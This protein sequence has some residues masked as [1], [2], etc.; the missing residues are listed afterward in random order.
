MPAIRVHHTDT[1]TESAWDGP[2]EVAAAPE[3]EA[4]L[5]Y[6]HAWVDP[7]ADPNTKTAYKFPHHAAGTDT[8][9]NIRG[10]NNALARLP[11]ADIPEGDRA[12]VEAHLRAHRED[13]GLEDAAEDQLWNAEDELEDMLA[14]KHIRSRSATAGRTKRRHEPIRVF[15]GSARPHEAFWSWKNAI[16]GGTED[17]G[18][19]EMELYGYISEFSWFDDDI[20]PK[21]FKKDLLTYGQGGPIT[22]KLNSPG[23]DVIAA[24]LISTM[25]RDYPG[26]VTV[27]IDGMA[28]SAATVV[29]L[30]G[31][32]VKIQDTAYFMIHDPLVAFF[33][34]VLNIEELNRLADSLQAVKEGIVNAYEAKTGLS[35]PRLSKM[36]TDETWMDAQKALDLGFV[37]EI[38]SQGSKIP[39]SLPQ[40][41]AVVNALRNYTHV[42]PAILEA[43]KS[44]HVPEATAASAPL[45]TEDEKREAQSLSERVNSILRKELHNA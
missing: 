40:N 30:A 24:S 38:L 29:A 18:E 22:I 15:E 41:T 9:A 23:G 6:M 28:A 7:D 32:I 26:R 39:V 11:Q 43:I 35:R 45:L 20:T 1:D 34:A 4:T 21:M 12:G 31:D 13:A 5:R 17:S 44:S 16:E 36:M 2:A 8:P 14:R 19:P 37:D 42:P 25:I 33:F 10:V 27:R 3:E